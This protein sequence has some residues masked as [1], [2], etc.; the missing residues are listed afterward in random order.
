MTGCSIPSICGSNNRRA[1][2]S[3]RFGSKRAHG[4]WNRRDPD[5][6]RTR[7]GGEGEGGGGE[8]EGFSNFT[9]GEKERN[10]IN[11]GGIIDSAQD[12]INKLVV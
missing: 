7:G 1:F 11:G 10:E 12:I 6:S 5:G 4:A 8:E 9:K 2:G 3:V